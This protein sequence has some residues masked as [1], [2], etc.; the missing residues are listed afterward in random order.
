MKSTTWM[1]L[2]ITWTG[3]DH[4]VQPYYIDEIDNIDDMNVDK[5]T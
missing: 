1:E 3:L 5:R 4:T 2:E